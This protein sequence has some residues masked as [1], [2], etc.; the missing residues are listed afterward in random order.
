MLKTLFL[1]ITTVSIGSS[2]GQVPGNELQGD[3]LV[4][5]RILLLDK[6]IQQAVVIGD[7]LLIDTTVATDFV[8]THGLLNGEVDTKATWRAF[9][10][11]SPKTF[12]CRDVDSAVV[13]IHGD[14]ALVCG[15]LNVKANFE[16]ENKLQTFCYSLHY[17]HLYQKRKNRWVLISHRTAKMIVPEYHCK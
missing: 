5:Q 12:F 1:I 3:S 11:A 6:K 14:V 9:A 17:V 15:R 10:K 13:E 8:F 2:F 4:K 7:T 16:E